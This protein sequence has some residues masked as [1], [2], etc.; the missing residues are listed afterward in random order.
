ME[1]DV[2]ERNIM[3]EWAKEKETKSNITSYY[4]IYNYTAKR[5]LN[6][7]N[8]PRQTLLLLNNQLMMMNNNLTA[9]K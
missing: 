3:W 4:F 2:S 5:T 7:D 1:I 9:K 8:N 6:D